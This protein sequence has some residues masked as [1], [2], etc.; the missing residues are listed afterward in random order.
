M[1]HFPAQLLEYIRVVAS[2]TYSACKNLFCER[3]SIFLKI[4]FTDNFYKMADSFFFQA[5]IAIRGYHVDK[6]T[7]W[8][9]TMK[10]EKVMLQLNRQK[11]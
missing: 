8:R 1:N 3:F 5:K 7:T 4:C 10:N 6:D 11:L 9:N 2:V